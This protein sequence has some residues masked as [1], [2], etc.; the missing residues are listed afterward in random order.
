MQNPF[1]EA[2]AYQYRGNVHDQRGAW[3]QAIT[4]FQAAR[5]VAERAGDLFRVY[6]VKFFEGRAYTMAGN[7]AQGRV[8]LEESLALAEQLGTTFGLV[9]AKTFFT[10]C[11]LALG[12]FAAVPPLC[13]EA[14]RLAE[15]AGDQFHNALAHR[16]LAEALY[17]LVPADLRQAERAI[18]EAIRLQ[19][20]IGAKPELA[21]T[22]V[23]YAR[24]LQGQGEGDKAKA[25]LTQAISMFQQMDM[26]WDLT[27]A[28][29]ALHATP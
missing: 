15:E 17:R 19:Q 21:R 26:A 22:Y 28:E 20:D 29:R 10:A 12:E 4:D 6:L 3:A 11:L 25:Y 5:R 8:L 13:H 27:Q 14:I 2:A 1:A 7:P 23:S 16:T 18:Q 9:M 24:L